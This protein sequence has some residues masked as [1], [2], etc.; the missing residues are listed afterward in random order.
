MII[1]VGAAI[2]AL[3]ALSSNDQLTAL[4]AGVSFASG[5][6]VLGIIIYL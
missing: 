5:V 2:V 3:G 4:T 6:T 1:I